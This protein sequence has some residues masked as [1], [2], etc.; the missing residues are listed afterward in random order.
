M[1]ISHDSLPYLTWYE[2]KFKEGMLKGCQAQLRTA[3]LKLALCDSS[4][5]HRIAPKIALL[6]ILSSIACCQLIKLLTEC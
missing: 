5:K 1:G 4:D 3:V 2:L 6:F